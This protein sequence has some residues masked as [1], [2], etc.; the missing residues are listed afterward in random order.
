[1]LIHQSLPLNILSVNEPA[2][3]WLLDFKTLKRKKREVKKKSGEMNFKRNI[4]F[5]LRSDS[6]VERGWDYGCH[7]HYNKNNEMML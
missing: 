1:M 7:W 2:L 4:A 5:L 6:I 3:M